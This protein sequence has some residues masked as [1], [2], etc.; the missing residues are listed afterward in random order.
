MYSFSQKISNKNPGNNY[1]YNIICSYHNTHNRTHTV[2]YTYLHTHKTALPPLRRRIILYTKLDTKF[3]RQ[4]SLVFS[5][6][7]LILSAMRGH[8]VH[9]QIACVLQ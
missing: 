6:C 2:I 1:S 8:R 3:G 7:T 5:D 4:Y 9:S